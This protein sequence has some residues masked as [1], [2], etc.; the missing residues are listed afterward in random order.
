MKRIGKNLSL[1]ISAL[2]LLLCPSL[3]LAAQNGPV[4]PDSVVAPTH[5]DVSPPL[6]DMAKRVGPVRGKVW[7]E[8]SEDSL[9]VAKKNSQP[10]ADAVEQKLATG[11]SNFTVGMNILGLGFGF[12][13]WQDC[14]ICF[15]PDTN[16][17]VG[18]T[19]VTEYVNVVY[20]VFDKS[21]GAT[22][23]GPVFENQLWAGFSGPCSTDQSGD[24]IVQFD[25]TAHRWLFYHAVLTDSPPFTLCFAIST[26]PDATGTYNRYQYTVPKNSGYPDY[27][28]MG[29]WTNSYFLTFLSG[30]EASCVNALDRAKMLVGDPSA[31][32]VSF[33]L[34][35]PDSSLLPADIDSS[36]PPPANED[37]FLIGG[38]RWQDTSHLALYSVHIDWSNPQGATITGAGGTQLIQI[39]T[40]TPACNGGY[41][42]LNDPC[43]PQLGTT[44]LIVPLGDRLMYRLAYF[45]DQ[46]RAHAGPTAGPIPQ[47]HWLLSHTAT[48]SQGQNA[49]RWYEFVGPEKNIPVTSISIAQ[50]GTY[51]PDTNFRQYPSIARD[52]A[53]DIMVG[54]MVSGTGIYPSIGMAGRVRTDPAGTLEPEQVVF[55]STLPEAVSSAW[56]DYTSMALDVSDNCTFWYVG[57]YY[58]DSNYNNWSTRIVSAKFPNC[59]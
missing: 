28:K 17:A 27:G 24:V 33:Q 48:A 36:T 10:I 44:N 22:I 3:N 30:G 19:Q 18:D 47:Q 46:V 31:E 11:P 45:N 34:S 43:V 35:K 55:A 54:Y 29:T 59:Q 2:T 8:D 32:M 14:S 26:S 15:V 39:A 40:F 41:G 12:P 37:E 16:L 20:G 1:L 42:G 50:Q 21:T 53:G 7:E 49:V 52:K 58:T 23:L 51:A 57:Q 6:R 25:K 13:N 4:H 38:V 56:G 5:F 9:G